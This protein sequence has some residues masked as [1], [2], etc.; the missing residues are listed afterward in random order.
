MPTRNL[1]DVPLATW[2]WRDPLMR[3]FLISLIIA[4][5]IFLE[6]CGDQP[7]YSPELR[8][9]MSLGPFMVALLVGALAQATLVHMFA[10][11]QGYFLLK[12]HGIPLQ[13]IMSGEQTPLRVAS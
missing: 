11:I 2:Q 8:Y 1:Q 10:Y 9:L 4:W 5:G 7:D 3:F 6:F 12:K 13:A